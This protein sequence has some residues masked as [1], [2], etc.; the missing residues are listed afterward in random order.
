LARTFN[1]GYCAFDLVVAE[2]G[3]PALL[4]I[5]PNGDWDYFESD[6]APVVTEFLA[7]TIVSRQA[8]APREP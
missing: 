3:R 5:T 6:P 7:D 4:D 2:D 1:L 8:G